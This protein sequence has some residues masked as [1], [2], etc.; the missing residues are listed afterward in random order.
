MMSR[1]AEQSAAYPDYDALPESP[2][3]AFGAASPGAPQPAN[4]SL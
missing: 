3:F 1:L 4:N 2:D